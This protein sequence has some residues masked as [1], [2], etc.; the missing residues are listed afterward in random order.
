[1]IFFISYGDNFFNAVQLFLA[2]CQSFVA[3][4]IS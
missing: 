4:A 2:E 1:M 3:Y